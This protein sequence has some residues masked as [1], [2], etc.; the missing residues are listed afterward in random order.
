MIDPSLCGFLCFDAVDLHLG[1]YYLACISP[2][3]IVS[4]RG[5]SS[6]MQI[7]C[8]RLAKNVNSCYVS[9]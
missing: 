8:F 5:F 7:S 3:P 1:M 6:N 4:N 2:T 9:I